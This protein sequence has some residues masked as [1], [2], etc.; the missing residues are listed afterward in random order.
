MGATPCCGERVSHC[1][2]FSGLVAQALGTGASALVHGVSCSSE[3]E[4]SNEPEIEPVSSVP[5]G[6]APSTTDI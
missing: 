5:P 2:G 4:S 6:K 3:C 1:R